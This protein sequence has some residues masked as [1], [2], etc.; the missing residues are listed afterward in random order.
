MALHTPVIQ[1]PHIPTAPNLAP[2]AI[3]LV[4]LA[5]MA[6]AV[7]LYRPA[8]APAEPGV[9]MNEQRQGEIDEGRTGPGSDVLIYRA[10][11]INA[12]NE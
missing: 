3:V 10:G 11:E 4:V 7:A 1:R 9:W 8:S 6:L 12:A 5:I 2:L